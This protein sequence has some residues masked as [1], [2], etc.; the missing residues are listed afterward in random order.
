MGANLKGPWQRVNSLNTRRERFIDGEEQIS[1]DEQPIPP[2]G[3]T[4][5]GAEP[6][7]AERASTPSATPAPAPAADAITPEILKSAY[8]AFKKRWKLTRL[9]QESRI[10]R[11]PMSGGQKSSIDGIIPPNQFPNSVWEA[12]AEKGRIKYTGSGFYAMP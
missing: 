10:G 9:D 2:T 12:L 6:I 7:E 1:M 8:N 4:D 11:G 3:E 5:T